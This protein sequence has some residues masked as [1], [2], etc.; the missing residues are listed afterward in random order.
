[1]RTMTTA[2]LTMML[3]ACGGGGDGDV[4]DGDGDLGDADAGVEEVDTAPPTIVSMLPANGAA[5]VRDDAPVV[6][7]FSESMDQLSV[8]NSL[9]TSDL[10]GVQFA[11]SDGGARLTI[12][13]DE[14]LL[15]ADGTDPEDVTAL[16][17]V[18]TI[19]TGAADEAGN[20][21][22]IGA[23]AIFTTL[24]EIA[25][26]VED[27]NALTGAVIPSD[28]VGGAGDDLYI[29]DNGAGGLSV[30]SRGL[31]T[32]DLAPVH[33]DAVEIVSATF[34]AFQ[35]GT[36]G[37]VFAELGALLIEHATFGVITDDL[38]TATELECNAAFNATALS[39]VGT[40]I[41]SDQDT[42]V[43][44]DVTAQVQDDLENRAARKDRSQFRLR[45][46]TDL[47]LDD[48]DDA[49]LLHRDFFDLDIV[50]LVP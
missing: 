48:G 45:L 41:S 18:V 47:N 39:S 26:T 10:G 50:Y 42:D 21:V 33:D 1:M 29:G 3:A 31:V 2:T 11:W 9:D 15:Y 34:K 6:I 35:S 19:G 5:G 22:E 14:P 40:L 25:V 13:P 36:N 38:A 44:I 46:S 37:A 12:T 20:H 30:G 28:A 17:Y 32:M 7:Q 23:Q 8:Q 49:V 16:Q 27:V 4:G 24:R 43:D